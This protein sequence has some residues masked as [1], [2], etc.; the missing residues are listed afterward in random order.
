M[1]V[2]YTPH[3]NGPTQTLTAARLNAPLNQLD[4]AIENIK[5]GLFIRPT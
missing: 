3:T 4:T 1:A 5:D 2:N